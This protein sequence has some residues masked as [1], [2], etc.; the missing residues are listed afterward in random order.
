MLPRNSGP[1]SCRALFKTGAGEALFTGSHHDSDFFLVDEFATRASG[2]QVAMIVTPVFGQNRY[3]VGPRIFGQKIV[4]VT[5]EKVAVVAE[6]KITV[7]A[8][9]KLAVGAGKKKH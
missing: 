7:A 6:Q 8:A 1:G 4:V 5:A 9:R 2:E 3:V